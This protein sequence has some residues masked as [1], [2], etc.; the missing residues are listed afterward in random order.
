[1]P[2]L[3]RAALLARLERWGELTER[4]R[5]EVR[6]GEALLTAMAAPRG[7]EVNDIAY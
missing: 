2:L 6:A 1:M 4:E 5:D 7:G 3:A